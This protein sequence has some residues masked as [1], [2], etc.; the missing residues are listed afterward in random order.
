[1]PAVAV[2]V[3]GEVILEAVVVVVVVAVLVVDAW[4][5]NLSAR[6]LRTSAEI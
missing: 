4:I 1:M 6:L 5:P 3:D 2:V